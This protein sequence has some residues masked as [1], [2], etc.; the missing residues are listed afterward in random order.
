MRR[1]LDIDLDHREHFHRLLIF[2]YTRDTP[3][4]ARATVTFYLPDGRQLAVN[5]HRAPQAQVRAD[6]PAPGLTSR[7]R[8]F[9]TVP[10]SAGGGSRRD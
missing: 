5:L 6:E 3:V 8:V 2:V 10:V 1:E 9:V 4:F 7:S